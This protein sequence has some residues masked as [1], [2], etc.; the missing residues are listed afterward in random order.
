MDI[1]KAKDILDY[2]FSKGIY[3][4]DYDKWFM[5]SE[6]YDEE[7]RDKFGA[8]L[9]EAEQGQGFGWLVRKDRYVE[10]IILMDQLCS[11]I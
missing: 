10:H 8:L 4:P 1:T 3:T 7:I 9:N 2:W 6:D 11:H 5:K